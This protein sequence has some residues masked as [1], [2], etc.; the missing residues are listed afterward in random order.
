MSDSSNGNKVYGGTDATITGTGTGTGTERRPDGKIDRTRPIIIVQGAQ[1]GSE[2]KGAV[3]AE[4]CLRLNVDC[5]VRTGGVNAGHTVYHNGIAYIMQ[6]LPTGWVN[7][8]TKL[9][10]G[11]GAYIN[12]KILHKETTT[13][14]YVGRSTKNRLY[15]DPRAGIHM[16]AHTTMSAESGRHHRIGATGK[17]CSE[18]VMDRIRFRGVGNALYG[19]TNG[20]DYISTNTEA[21]LNDAY[22]DGKRILLEGTQG[23]GLDIL[24]GPWPYVTHKP[25]SPAQWMV[26]NGLSPALKTEIVAVART[27]PIRVA[28]NSGP[29]P[30]EIR[31][32]DL[33]HE[34]GRVSDHALEVWNK[35]CE[36]VGEEWAFC[37]P[38]RLPRWTDTGMANI[39]FDLW[40]QYQRTQYADGVSEFH[41]EVFS[42][43]YEGVKEELGKLFEFTTVTKKLRRIARW[44]AETMKEAMRQMR[45][46]YVVLTFLNY[47]FP[48]LWGETEPD[49]VRAHTATMRFIEKRE[50]ELGVEIKYVTTGPEG[51]NMIE[52]RQ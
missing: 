19:S 45:P 25:T 22:D 5:A 43:L 31:W 6:Q 8:N 51:K 17:G 50:K 38:P 48:E 18:A 33:A 26:E 46:Q 49:K 11:P 32:E 27:Y 52:I 20:G 44:D 47:E 35:T 41:K 7:P 30:G 3:A 37:S 21:L 9:V 10:I 34:I 23:Q 24:L 2:A 16:D 1:W 28:G 36:A 42:R 12:R 29:M 4:L 39:R 40:P 15:I 13:L 14:S